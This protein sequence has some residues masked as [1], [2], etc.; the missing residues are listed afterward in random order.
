MTSDFGVHWIAISI[1]WMVDFSLRMLIQVAIA[2]LG[3]TAFFTAPGAS[4]PAHLII[5]GLVLLSTGL[6]GVIAAQVAERAEV[7]NGMLVGVVGILA[8][9]ASSLGLQPT[10]LVMIVVQVLSLATGALGGLVVRQVR[11]KAHAE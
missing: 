4:N 10:P 5:I 3:L 6:G 7:L 8:V 9:A 2:W 11:L 1:G